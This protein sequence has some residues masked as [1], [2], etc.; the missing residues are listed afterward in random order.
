MTTSELFSLML[1]GTGETLYMTVLSSILAYIIG[2]P[3]GVI[4]VVTDINGIK[5]LPV[6]NRVLG[7]VVNVLR[8]IPFIILLMLM[9]PVTR[10]ILGT[11]LGSTAVVIPLTASA[12]P[13]VA[14]MV[15]SSLK[16][17]DYGV[18]EAAK[19]MGASTLQIIVKVMIPE[20]RPS[21]LIGSAI[22]ITTILGYSTMSG[23]V[24]GG[25]LG[26]I[27]VRYGVH[28]YNLEVMIV[29][30]VLIVLVVQAIQS[31][32]TGLSNKTDKRL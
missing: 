28:R 9:I 12:A 1:Q 3:L 32:G 6:F 19:S 10:F 27:A 29:A 16:E 26:D 7:F 17:I 30:V 8:S 21:L 23:F 24:G 20:A 13:Y 14:R 18:I 22:A 11:T 5:P 25:G 2:L 4:L 31:I 15:E